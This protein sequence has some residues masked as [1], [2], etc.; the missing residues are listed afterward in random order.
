[1]RIN[2]KSVVAWV[3]AVAFVVAIV[4]CK[5]S[6]PVDEHDEHS[7]SISSTVSGEQATCPIMKGNPINKNIFTE[8]N[9]KKVYFC[10]EMCIDK[11]KA[12]PEQYVSQLPQFS[13]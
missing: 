5:K 1:M 3:L 11:F 4:G 9:G 12:E 6:T 2:M 7:E 13:K 10:C 8:Y